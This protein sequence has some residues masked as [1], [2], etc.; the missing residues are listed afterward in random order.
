MIEKTIARKIQEE[1]C[2]INRIENFYYTHSS[3]SE[4]I[5]YRVLVKQNHPAIDIFH[6][7]KSKLYGEFTE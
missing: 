4:S 1:M 7:V 2:K 6:T 5:V 3:N